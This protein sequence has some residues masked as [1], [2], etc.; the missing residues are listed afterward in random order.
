MSPSASSDLPESIAGR[1]QGFLFGLAPDG[2]YTATQR[3]RV[4]GALLPH[5]FTLTW[6]PGGIFSVALSVGSRPPGVTW[7]PALWS[8]DFPLMVCVSK[9]ISGCLADSCE[10]ATLIQRNIN[11]ILV[12]LP[13]HKITSWAFRYVDSELRLPAQA[14]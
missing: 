8:P 5:H 9:V 6:K 13:D 2:V 10:Q 4:C 7:H 1:N 12:S 3:Y 14:I 11:R